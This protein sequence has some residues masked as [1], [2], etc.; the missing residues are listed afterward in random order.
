MLRENEQKYLANLS[1]QEANKVV[2]LHDYNPEIANIAK[3][4]MHQIKQKLPGADMRFLGASA[5][6]IS[7]QNDIDIYVLASEDKQKEYFTKLESLFG[8]HEKRKW[9]WQQ[10]GYE[11][12]V[13]LADPDDPEQ[14][15]QIEVFEILHNS[16]KLLKEYEQL[17][18]AV[19]GKTYKEYQTTKYEFYNK[20]LESK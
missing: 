1:E 6:G 3:E 8:P 18:L 5:L 11:V 7:G 14:K 9:S 13:Y 17:K 16:P 10:Q 4:V 12:S 19:N 2:E 20:I 15:R